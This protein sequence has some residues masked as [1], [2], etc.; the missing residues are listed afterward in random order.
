MYL[1]HLKFLFSLVGG[2]RKSLSRVEIKPPV[3]LIGTRWVLNAH[4]LS[5]DSDLTA[6]VLLH[7]MT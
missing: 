2:G 5:V 1:S 3:I 4:H 7:Y 6:L